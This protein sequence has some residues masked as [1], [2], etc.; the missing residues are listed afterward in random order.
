MLAAG[1]PVLR[2]TPREE[3]RAKEILCEAM[4]FAI[5]EGYHCYRAQERAGEMRARNQGDIRC[6]V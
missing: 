2:V 4:S 1:L 6:T 5:I 3:A